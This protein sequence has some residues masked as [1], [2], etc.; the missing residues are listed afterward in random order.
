MTTAEAQIRQ[1]CYLFGRQVLYII[2]ASTIV[3]IE[4]VIAADMRQEGKG[5][6]RRAGSKHI[7]PLWGDV[8]TRRRVGGTE[9]VATKRAVR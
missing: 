9:S 7:K 2:G 4:R 8:P 5:T 6:R 1:A 3:E